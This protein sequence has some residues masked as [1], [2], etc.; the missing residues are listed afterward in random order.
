MPALTFNY[1][2]IEPQVRQALYDSLGQH[3]AVSTEEVD[4]GRVFVK[5]VAPRLNGLSPK[6]KQDV[7]WEALHTLG[8]E[9]Q[10]VSLVLAFGT[11]EI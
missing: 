11:D 8:P 5:V 9:A 7:V 6:D 10:A 3:I 4:S 1:Q 2:Q